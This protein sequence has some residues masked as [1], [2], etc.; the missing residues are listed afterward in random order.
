VDAGRDARLAAHLLRIADELHAAGL[1]PRLEQLPALSGN[2]RLGLLTSRE[3][4]VLTRLL[5]G[6]RPAAIAKDLMVSPSTVRNQLSSIYAKLR[7]N[8]QVDLIRTL[9]REAPA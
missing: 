1:L 2:P 8:G 3:W 7:V 6:Q 5:D 4:T 9:R